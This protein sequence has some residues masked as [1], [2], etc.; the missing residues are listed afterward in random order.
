MSIPKNPLETFD[1]VDDRRVLGISIRRS[2]RYGDPGGEMIVE[3]R[4]SDESYVELGR[5]QIE[6]CFSSYWSLEK[7][8]RRNYS[9][10]GLPLRQM[11]RDAE[12]A[13]QLQSN[14]WEGVYRQDLFGD[15]ACHIMALVGEVEWLESLLSGIDIERLGKTQEA[16]ACLMTADSDLLDACKY[17]VEQLWRMEYATGDGTRGG[18]LLEYLEAIIT[19]AESRKD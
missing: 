4:L 5:E 14:H 12:A 3:V 6:G 16:K 17:A 8:T 19:Q 7:W 9:T 1:V 13:W 2:G 15:L 10:R 18:R 11:L